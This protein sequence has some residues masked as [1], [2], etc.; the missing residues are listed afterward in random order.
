MNLNVTG[1][2]GDGTRK[3]LQDEA[4]AMG[5][6]EEFISQLV[7]TFYDK[8]RAH[9]ELGPVFDEVIQDHWHPHLQKMKLFWNSIALRT[10]TYRGNPMPIHKALTNA[11]PG[12]FA[13]WLALFRETL[14]EIA[15]NPQVVEYFMGFAVVMGERLSSA[16]FS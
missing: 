13:I 9:P 3:R 15:P 1:D 14:T 2:L 6:S 11:K 16:M 12:H 7:D 10:G 5:V 8:V 4:R